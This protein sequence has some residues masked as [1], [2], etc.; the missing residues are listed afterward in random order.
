MT[1]TDALATGAKELRKS[2]IGSAA[3]EAELLLSAVLKK[4]REYLLIHGDKE[5]TKN[6][7]NQFMASVQERKTHKPLAYIT[8]EKEFYGLPFFVNEHVLIPRPETEHIVDEAKRILAYWNARKRSFYVVDIGTG[9]GCIIIALLRYHMQQNTSMPGRFFAS[10]CSPEAIT[11]AQKNA[12]RHGVENDIQ[13]LIGN[14]LEPFREQKQDDGEETLVVANLPYVP[15]HETATLPLAYEPRIALDGGRDGLDVYR[16]LIQELEK[17]AP[18]LTV[19]LECMPP[20]I[21]LAQELIHYSLPD[22]QIHILQDL[23]QRNRILHIR[24]EQ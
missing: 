7:Q 14:L 6:E 2:H 23:A 10:D 11:L 4:P 15:S 13:F 21:P 22:A 12:K 17:L 18:P 8:G 3:L 20:Q 1:I 24:Y 5:L 9:S 19:L 16:G